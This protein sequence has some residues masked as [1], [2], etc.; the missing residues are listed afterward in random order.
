MDHVWFI[1]DKRRELTRVFDTP[2]VK[3]ANLT[4]FEMDRPDAAHRETK[5]DPKLTPI[6]SLTSLIQY[7]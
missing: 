3:K 5:K 6:T 4:L 7:L 2:K 1:D